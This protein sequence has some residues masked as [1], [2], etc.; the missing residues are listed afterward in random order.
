MDPE[1]IKFVDD[2]ANIAISG[3]WAAVKGEIDR[4]AAN[5]GVGN[6]WYV[7]LIRSLTFQVFSEYLQ[8]KKAYED[9]QGNDVSLLAWRARNLLELSV[10]SIYWAKSKEN[11][12]HL[13][14]DAGRDVVDLVK[15]FETVSQATGQS[16]GCLELLTS[17]K[18]DMIKRSAADGIE[19]LDGPYKKVEVAAE[20][21]GIKDYYKFFFKTL[22]KFAH[23]TA[24]R[25][26]GP[27]GDAKQRDF[28]FS[29]G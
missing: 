27:P 17:A 3:R 11:A 4:L 5:P 13:Y 9:K 20:V 18:Q 8:I 10:W 29:Q 1:F 12:H 2:A 26:L 21:C 28:L 22:S 16:A 6:E 25:I 14:E 7:Q 19:T 24:M 15:A 23:P